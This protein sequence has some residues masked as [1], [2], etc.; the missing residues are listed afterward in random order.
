MAERELKKAIF[1]WL[2]PD[3][4][5][6]LEAIIGI[7]FWLS[8]AFERYSASNAGNESN[9]YVVCVSAVI[10]VAGTGGSWVKR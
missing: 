3:T 6:L 9:D 10:K 5:A 4:L 8:S 7:K 1:Y 2:L